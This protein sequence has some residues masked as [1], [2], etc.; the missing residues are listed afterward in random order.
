MVRWILLTRYGEIALKS[1]RS[2][3]R[4]ER[5]LV[6]NIADALTSEGMKGRV[7]VSGARVWVCCFD[8]EE[9][10][11]EAS[12][13][14]ARVMG[15][16][17][18]SPSIEIRFE[19]LEDLCQKAR[20]FFTPR[21]KGRV[22]AVRAHR[23]GHHSFTSKDVEKVLGKMLLDSGASR[24]DLENPEYEAYVEIRGDRAYLF[25]KV[26][27]GPGGL[28]IGVEGTVLSLFSGGIDSPVA[29]W[30]AMKRGC[31]VHMA[32]FN[33]GGDP[34]IYS[35]LA[36][37]K[38]LADR[39]CYG[40]RPKLYVIDIRPIALKIAQ[41]SPEEYIVILLRRA[42]MRLAT[43]LAKDIGA[44]AL[45]TGESLGQVASQTLRNLAVI[46]EAS[47][48][49]VLRPLIGM[50]KQEITEIARRIGTY[51][52]SSKMVEYCPMGTRKVTTRASLEKVREIESRIALTSDE[53][54]KTVEDRLEFDLRSIPIDEVLE[55]LK[56]VSGGCRA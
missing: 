13:V 26:I 3:S 19:S 49:P 34:Q 56:S 35:A 28:P 5:R 41:H 30:F 38:V 9:S 18:V 2:R 43:Y 52:L 17:S 1:E 15:V 42:M 6:S 11:L 23:V 16:V 46:D 44:E 47:E 32:L 7:W 24:V 48:L 53:L 37:A 27:E 31:E 51:E 8:S 22:F 29:T 50:D 45:V 10:A 39:W 54:V 33:I 36:V 14:V 4:M 55:K 25:D 40:Y 21:V 12:K 20:E